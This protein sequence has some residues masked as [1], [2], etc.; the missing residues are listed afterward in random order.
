MS[1]V[2]EAKEAQGYVDWMSINC[3]TCKHFTSRM[4][5]NKAWFGT[6]TVEKDKRCSIGGFVV[7][8]TAHCNMW[9]EKQ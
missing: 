3:S 9:E 6:H 1:K 2:S 4:E 7:K 5:T 8:K